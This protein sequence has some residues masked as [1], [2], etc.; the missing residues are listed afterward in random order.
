MMKQQ[1][2]RALVI[3]LAATLGMATMTACD[4]PEEGDEPAADEEAEAPEMPDEPEA[5]GDQPGQ[6]EMALDGPEPGGEEPPMPMQGP[7][8]DEEVSDED[9]DNFGEAI[10]AIG[11]L[12]EEA[13]DPQQRM[14]D[15]ETQQ[16]RQEIQQEMIGELQ[17]A[18]EDSGMQFQEF[19][20]L[21]QRLQQD[22]E[23]QQRLSERVDME[24]LMGP[25]PEQPQPP[26]GQQPGAP[27]EAPTLD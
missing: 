10:E 19:M 9:L 14:E 13:E 21:S 17:G 8:M 2:V 4:A 6:D 20:M 5:P 22:P 15:A 25:A 18:V 3:A 26:A 16:E 23:L 11:E 12:Q 24:E 1:I 7:D 27:Q